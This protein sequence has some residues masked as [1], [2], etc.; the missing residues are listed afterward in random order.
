MANDA[1]KKLPQW[2]FLS[3]IIHTRTSLENLRVYLPSTSELLLR[4]VYH[5]QR[6]VLNLSSERGLEHT[7]VGV[8]RFWAEMY[9]TNS[10]SLTGI[11]KS[12]AKKSISQ[13]V[14]RK[15][16][17]TTHPSSLSLNLQP[18]R[19]KR[20]VFAVSSAICRRLDDFQ[21]MSIWH[22]LLTLA[23][24][25]VTP[26]RQVCL[27]ATDQKPWNSQL[28]VLNVWRLAGWNL[29]VKPAF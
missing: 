10:Q 12:S 13:W 21:D 6:S 3:T 19:T 23:A 7:S 11:I 8:T 9:N 4:S 14:I 26:W 1:S 5:L 17:L 27:P 22:S 20:N 29:K 2:V 16:Y 18:H 28:F 24:T 15:V 25:S